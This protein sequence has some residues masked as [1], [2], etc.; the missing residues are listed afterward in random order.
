MRNTNRMLMLIL[1]LLLAAAAGVKAQQGDHPGSLTLMRVI[2]VF[3]DLDGEK[4]VGSLPYTLTLSSDPSRPNATIASLR[5]GVRVPIPAQ[6]SPNRESTVQYMNVGTDID[7]SASR[8]P[9]GRYKLN[10]RLRR[11][12]VDSESEKTRGGGPLEM[13]PLLR[14]FEWSTDLLIRDG[15]TVQSIASTDPVSGRVIHVNV[16]LNVLK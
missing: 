7:V 4:K 12:S 14:S 8:H 3:T 16:T 10:L 13:A 5:A 9:D 2:V 1:A 6:S 15:E 11:S